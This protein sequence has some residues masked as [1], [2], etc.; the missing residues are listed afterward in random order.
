MTIRRARSYLD[1]GYGMMSEFGMSPLPAHMS[2]IVITR[3]AKILGAY[4]GAAEVAA[5]LQAFLISRKLF[6]M[7][8]V[9]DRARVLLADYFTGLA[10]KLLSPLS[11]SIV[12]KRI[13]TRLRSE[14]VAGA[15][16]PPALDVNEYLEWVGSI[17]REFL[18]SGKR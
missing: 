3:A 16:T 14:A 12:V 6:D 5:A 10:V 8:G 1:E 9:D 7:D 4:E 17:C 13:S 11:S 15:P 18:N 2:D